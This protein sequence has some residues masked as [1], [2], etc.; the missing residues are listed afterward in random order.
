MT[1]VLRNLKT[2]L[3]ICIYGKIGLQWQLHEAFHWCFR[4]RSYHVFMVLLCNCSQICQIRWARW[5]LGLQ[6][7]VWRAH[8]AKM[9]YLCFTACITVGYLCGLIGTDGSSSHW[10][11]C[12][13]ILSSV[14][15]PSWLLS[16]CLGFK[17]H[18][19]SMKKNSKLVKEGL[20]S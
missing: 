20:R 9:I 17:R 13:M 5:A 10:P 12:F 6:I 4:S 15:K 16:S 18:S 2:N 11:L 8:I 1:S 3:Y 19:I 7:F 14:Y